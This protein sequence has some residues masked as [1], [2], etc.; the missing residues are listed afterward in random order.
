MEGGSVSGT[1]RE[2]AATMRLSKERRQY[3]NYLIPAVTRLRGVTVT[4]AED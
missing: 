4:G 3:N 2:F 1:M